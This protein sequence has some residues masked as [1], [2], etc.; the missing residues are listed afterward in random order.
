MN[1]KEKHVSRG[2]QGQKIAEHPTGGGLSKISWG[3]KNGRNITVAE[4]DRH[5]LEIF[6]SLMGEEYI[7]FTGKGLLDDLA[8]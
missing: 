8:C 3:G 5:L 6:L 4:N 2:L 1:I 7:S